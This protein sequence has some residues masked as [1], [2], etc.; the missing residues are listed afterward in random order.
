MAFP[1]LTSWNTLMD[2]IIIGLCG[3]IVLLLVYNQ[4]KYRK[5]IL[6]APRLDHATEF[7]RE[8]TTA[9]V[10][11]RFEKSFTAILQTLESERQSIQKWI[12]NGEV[13]AVEIPI[14]SK[15]NTAMAM[16]HPNTDH[17]A[18]T[19]V[20]RMQAVTDKAS[21]MAANGAGVDDICDDLML[22]R[23]CV[24]LIV[25]MNHAKHPHYDPSGLEDPASSSNKENP[26]EAEKIA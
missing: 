12:D 4:I 5:L 16:P 7:S 11:Q 18:E 21:N 6:K 17:Y 13:A 8:V 25:H 20:A 2:L 24:E 22:P 9:M 14:P 1:F 15:L 3:V 26:S 10:H 23:E 19:E